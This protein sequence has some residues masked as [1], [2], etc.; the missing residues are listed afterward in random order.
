M[1]K[2]TVYLAGP[3][4]DCNDA[5][6]VK[7]RN[8]VKAK[9]SDHFDFS[10]PIEKLLPASAGNSDIV[11]EDVR[12]IEESDGIIVNMWRES[13]G[14]AIGMVHAHIIGKP[15]VTSNPNHIGS[16]ALGFYSD[17]LTDSPLKAAKILRNILQAEG[18]LKVLKSHEAGHENFSRRKLVESLRGVCRDAKLDDILVPRLAFPIIIENLLDSKRNIGNQ[19]TSS[20]INSTVRQSF[21]Q[22]EAG[23]LTPA[24]K[25]NLLKNW[26]EKNQNRD[27]PVLEPDVREPDEKISVPVSCT[28]SHG[29]IWG[30]TITATD[31]LPQK[32]RPIFSCIMKTPGITRIKL[33]QFGRGQERNTVGAFVS[34]STTD[35]LLDGK[36]FDKGAKG[37][38]QEIQVWVQ[39]NSN[40]RSILCH[41]RNSLIEEGLW[42]E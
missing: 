1:R 31:Q 14:S 3:I 32:V 16:K 23:I 35:N 13:I 37:T 20:E 29:T 36:I 5:Q 2:F 40:K 15:V 25:S 11:K 8:E 27:L 38:V 42:R 33:G 12:A 22:L 4:G 26:E 19:V 10:D 24:S 30:N 17:A 21:D 9:Y 18:N 28:D 7:W 39:F 41:I 34:E 6:K